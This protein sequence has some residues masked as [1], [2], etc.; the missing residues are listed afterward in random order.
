M[1]DTLLRDLIDLPETVSRGD[2]VLNLDRGVRDPDTTLGQ[3]VVTPQLVKHF[4]EALKVIQGAVASRQSRGTYLDG[5]FGSGKSH[6]MAV[7]SFLLAGVMKARTMPK[8]APVVTAHDPWMHQK[9]FLMV[10][11]HMIGATSLES[12]ILGG[13]V[14]HVR[15]HHPDAPTPAVFRAQVWIEN[16]CALRAELG[17]QAF[18]RKLNQGKATGGDEGWGALGGGWDA[19]SFDQAVAAG[20]TDRDYRRLSGDLIDAYFQAVRREGDYVSLDEG[21]AILSAHARNLGYDALILF[22]DEMILWLASNASNV[23]FI[24]R[25]VPKVSKLVESQHSA[26]AIPIVS[27]IA[28]QRDLRELI[29]DHVMG[30]QSLNFADQLK[31][32]EGRFG[33]IK[34]EDANLPYIVEERVLKPRQESARRLIDDEFAR[35]AQV[36][37]AV[38][39]VLLTR[40]SNRE[41]FRRLYPFSPA[42]VETLVAVSSLLQRERT[43]LKIMLQL[44]VDQKDTLRLG[45]LVPVGDLYDEIAQGDEAFSADMKRHFTTADQL[46]RRQLRPVLEET[47]G[48]TF[49]AAAKL[50]Y[51]D[52]KRVALRADDRLIKTLLLAALAPAVESLKNLTPERLAAL[53]HGTIK[54]PIPGQEA[55]I[56][57]SKLRNFAGRCGQIKIQEGAA[58]PVVSI[59]LSGVDVEAI[60][61]RANDRDNY[62]NRLRLLQAKLLEQLGLQ[63]TDKLWI[64]HTVTWRGTPRRCKVFFQNI[65]EAEDEVLRNDGE[66]WNVLI[67]FPIDQ[68]GHGPQDDLARLDT[69]RTRQGST[70]TLAW[71]PSALS[72]A[73]QDQLGRLV[74]LVHILEESRFRSFVQDLSP[75]DQ[76]SARSIL[77]NLRDAQHSAL[78]GQLT[79]AYGLNDRDSSGA[80]AP[81]LSLSGEDHFQSLDTGLQPR[82][83]AATQLKAA[84]EEILEQALVSQFPGHPI[85]DRDLRLNKSGVERVLAVLS[86]NLRCQDHRSLVEKSDRVLVRQITL[87][88][89]LGEMGETHFVMGE[90]WRNHF[91][92]LAAK[93]GILD[94]MKVGDLRR[95]MDE[96]RPMGL[97]T[98]L[99][100]LLIL[101]FAQQTNRSITRHGVAWE[102]GLQDLPDDCLLRMQELPTEAQWDQAVTLA[103]KVLGTVQLPGFVSGQNV[104]LF[105]EKVKA[106]AGEL[107]GPARKLVAELR[108]RAADFQCGDPDRAPRILAAREANTFLDLV[109][110]ESQ[111]RLI[112]GMAELRLESPPEA[113]A[114]S[115][116]SAPKLLES[117]PNLNLRA[118]HAA[119]TLPGELGQE[120]QRLRDELDQAFAQY[121]YAVAFLPAWQRIH[122]RAIQLLTK[123]VGT[124]PAPAIAPVRPGSKPPIPA[125]DTAPR[126]PPPNSRSQVKGDRAPEGLAAD[127]LR[128]IL[129]SVEVPTTSGTQSIWVSRN[130]AA[131]LQADGGAT[132]D[133]TARLLKLPAFHWQG[134]VETAP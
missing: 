58:Q 29:G 68:P 44:L 87:P 5:S 41:A 52:P 106:A 36:R 2:F 65:R 13:Y 78:I 42:L 129:V 110:N 123:A 85:F 15:E 115:L 62:G 80:T 18:F 47:H 34:L 69:F 4:D 102:A 91:H 122:D 7:L 88:L 74:R 83:P 32:W 128:L 95:W 57:L 81:D 19:A 92:Q 67:D 90:Y 61:E 108:H 16:A 134:V 23:D 48:L 38:M 51:R 84:F 17:D 132:Y 77:R 72:Q 50:D 109:K 104:A 133:E 3:Y 22:L 124:G 66:L 79:I 33:Q 25:E 103:Q 53:N 100:N 56:V 43:A 14:R 49:A 6:F 116:K 126:Q 59:Q 111:A 73:A 113:L 8:L 24:S 35:T 10:P 30:V 63:E 121:E 114:S 98:L 27:F 119:V 82:V 105:N 46:Y 37:E 86:D 45:E 20:P 76:E 11:Y 55:S 127:Y 75:Q 118:I 89:R 28:R 120:G 71:I 131:L 112:A 31:Y 99:Q 96:P 101:V 60:L 97:P 125:V 70:R 1:P 107:A 26:R 64:E 94:G 117:L 39:N 21:L 40:H 130:L 54:S 9:R 93:N 12:A